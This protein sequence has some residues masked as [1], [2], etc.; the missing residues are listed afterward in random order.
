MDQTSQKRQIRPRVRIRQLTTFQL[1]QRLRHSLFVGGLAALLIPAS[2]LAAPSNKPQTLQTNSKNVITTI[3]GVVPKNTN[4]DTQ[5]LVIKD[6]DVTPGATNPPL[7][8]IYSLGRSGLDT[9]KVDVMKAGSNANIALFSRNNVPGS[10][11]SF[12]VAK[13]AFNQEYKLRLHANGNTHGTYVHYVT[14]LGDVDANGKVDNADIAAIT[15]QL[16]KKSQTTPFIGDVNRDGRVS[17]ADTNLAKQNMGAH[18]GADMQQAGNPLDTFLPDNAVTLTGVDPN[19]FN[20]LNSALVFHLSV[21]SFAN[22][23]TDTSVTINKSTVNSA[24]IAVAGNTITV[25]GALHDGKNDIAFAAHDD[26]GRSVYLTQTV[27]AGQGSLNVK[28][29]NS[30]K[31][32]FL[33]QSAITFALA[34]DQAVVAKASTA[35]GTAQFTNLPDRTFIV[36]ATADNNVLGTGGGVLSDGTIAIT[37][38]GLNTPSSVDNNDF[39][40]GLD[41]WDTS[42]GKASIVAHTEDV[43]PKNTLFKALAAPQPVARDTM[44][45]IFSQ[46]KTQGLQTFAAA[47]DNDLLLSTSG[48]GQQ[49]VSRT[50]TT[51]KGTSAVKMRYRFVT[52]EVPG[53]YFGTK[54]N[55]YFKVSLRTQ[56]GDKEEANSM[57]AMG[58]ASFD[59]AGSTTWRNVKI[60]TDP[61]GDT[62]QADLAVANVADGLLDSYVV[63]D[64]IEQVKVTVTPTI[65]WNNTQGGLDVSYEVKGGDLEDERQLTV[66]FASGAEYSNR[67]GTPFFTKAVPA[68][69]KEGTYGPFHIDGNKLADDPA[70]TTTILAATSDTDTAAIDDVKVNFGA[71]A[72]AGVVAPA[73]LDAI[74]DGLRAAGQTQATITSTAR[75]PED[76]A[77]AMFNNL[78]NP[79]HTVSQNTAA[80]HAL[81]AAAGDAVI[82]AFTTATTGMTLAQINANAATVQ[83]AMVDEINNQGCDKV[84]AH[85]AD[86]TKK[87]VV[88][89][90][91]SAFNATN[92]PIFRAAVQARVT[93]TL[94]EPNNHCYHF[95]LNLQ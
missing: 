53:G 35:T 45:S 8:A 47:A 64:S 40:K 38:T 76:Q 25:T 75:G 21:G 14:L 69:T 24:N 41:G 77:R 6:T 78:V 70:G 9:G 18:L 39:S 82:D 50:F 89:V 33:K 59:S 57:N 34:D 19:A 7:I 81:Y 44:T 13:L 84:T 93:K 28:L 43:G 74:K 12:T 88:D 48:E 2:A 51:D 29:L 10:N 83:Q 46:Q 1:R 94:D 15:R 73:L 3:N 90:G 67:L 26:Q 65:K 4:H 95:E 63:V 36:K 56:K 42:K 61:K 5:K 80:Q 20:A 91:T 62:L 79:A 72:N 27:W 86:P 60:P 58:L 49:N 37:M 32:A 16:G 71:N 66:S 92:G 52:T 54:Y 68:G 31:T 23:A 17:A 30:D 22:G 55:D 87:S 11:D 85:C